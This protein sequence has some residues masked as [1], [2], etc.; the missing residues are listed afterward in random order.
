MQIIIHFLYNKIWCFGEKVVPLH[1]NSVSMYVPLTENLEIDRELRCVRRGDEI[2]RLT[3]LECG[4]LDYLA[5]H[6]NHVCTRNEILNAVWGTRFRYDTGTIDVHLNALRRKMGWNGKQPIEAIRGA[7][8]IFRIEQ[9]QMHYTIDL[10]SFLNEWLLSHELETRT[11][12]MVTQIHLTPFVNDITIAPES[13]RRM[14]DGILAALLPNAQPGVLRLTT[15]LTVQYFILSLNIN[16]T[17][18]EL[19]IPIYGDFDVS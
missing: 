6:A 16:G 13:L 4:L 9:K 7:G 12:G 15:K 8:L 14:L 5:S 11:A 10:Q 1:T 3:G 2:I 19:R 18:G 17:T